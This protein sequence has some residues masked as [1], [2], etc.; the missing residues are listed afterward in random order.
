MWYSWTVGTS[1]QSPTLRQGLRNEMM[2]P[3]TG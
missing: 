2:E 3:L 1:E